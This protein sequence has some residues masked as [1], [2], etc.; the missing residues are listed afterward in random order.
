MK[1]VPLK[2]TCL[3]VLVLAGIPTLLVSASTKPASSSIFSTW[4]V[5]LRLS[6]VSQDLVPVDVNGAFPFDLD[7]GR[8]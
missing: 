4:A 6:G 2:L 5:N 3:V 8:S 1:R 7:D